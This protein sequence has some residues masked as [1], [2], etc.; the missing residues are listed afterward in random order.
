MGE[1]IEGGYR[2]FSSLVVADFEIVARGGTI[3]YNRDLEVKMDVNPRRY[4]FIDLQ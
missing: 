1:R 4:T 2:I 3:S